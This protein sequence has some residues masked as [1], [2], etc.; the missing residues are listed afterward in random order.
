MSKTRTASADRQRK[1]LQ[2]APLELQI[3]RRFGSES[4]WM[5][6]RSKA[7]RLFAQHSG[8]GNLSVFLID[9]R[10]GFLLRTFY[11]SLRRSDFDVRRS[12]FDLTANVSSSLSLRAKGER[13]TS[14]LERRSEETGER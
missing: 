11:S 3:N 12:M 14:N 9:R 5:R 6:S 13:P 2:H 8:G 4:I 10:R 7:L 1:Q